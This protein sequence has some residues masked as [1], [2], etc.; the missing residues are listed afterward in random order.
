MTGKER[1]VLELRARL[2]G[3]RD[4]THD[5]CAY[6]MQIRLEQLERLN[7]ECMDADN[8]SESLFD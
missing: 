6:R 4:H 2:D 8:S 3:R 5:V 7:H 1:R